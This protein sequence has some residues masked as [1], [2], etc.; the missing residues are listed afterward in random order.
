MFPK[1]G[2]ELGVTDSALLLQER[3]DIDVD[4]AID[5]TTIRV[6]CP[7]PG[8]NRETSLGDFM[9]SEHGASVTQQ[10]VE[11]AAQAH[12]K[13]A[14]LDE[15]LAQALGFAAVR[16]KETGGLARVE[17]V[18]SKKN[19][20]AEPDNQ[21]AEIAN[22][23]KVAST[24]PTLR[25]K[26]IDP[27]TRSAAIHTIKA[28][29]ESILVRRHSMEASR[30]AA[31][32]RTEL[33]HHPAIT[34][35][36]DL[37]HNDPRVIAKKESAG[38]NLL[39]VATKKSAPT[40]KFHKPSVHIPP[41]TH[42][43][44]VAILER[45][46]Q[47]IPDTRHQAIINDYVISPVIPIK[48]SPA[49]VRLAPTQHE[50]GLDDDALLLFVNGKNREIPIDAYDTLEQSLPEFELASSPDNTQLV[51]HESELISTHV[52]LE[53]TPEP[54]DYTGF[55][56]MEAAS[57]TNEI[58]EIYTFLLAATEIEA[59]AAPVLD[60]ELYE[61]PTSGLVVTEQSET[62][63]SE[64]TI[65]FQV[66]LLTSHMLEP[67]PDNEILL[68]T[69]HE[70][71][72]EETLVLLSMY[73]ADKAESQEPETAIIKYSLHQMVKL[74]PRNTVYG[75][76]EAVKKVVTPGF[77]KILVLLLRTVGY[78]NPEQILAEL[79]N[80]H[81]FEFLVQAIRYLYQLCDENDQLELLLPH[82]A[83]PVAVITE[84][85]FS[86]RLGRALLYFIGKHETF[87]LV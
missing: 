3:L 8:Q 82:L 26:V 17:P 25:E 31:A 10:I 46:S 48:L 51:L 42:G 53:P 59:A 37:R 61:A 22:S 27:Q 12:E 78:E 83:A 64:T 28:T 47:I 40:S 15:A 43:K 32:R 41:V 81:S 2:P 73:L 75:V 18:E 71:P 19:L 62:G 39:P 70:K 20:G 76:P 52:V 68:S 49:G 66:S 63:E 7:F 45:P 21:K 11:T 74:L 69:A 33:V 57:Y 24:F 30:L 50:A 60:A 80:K 77:T 36:I 55:E 56:N 5:L 6:V 87:S 16:D 72:L 86:V 58:M 67:S 44:K 54:W 14:T 84:K 29:E 35:H 34:G 1:T 4:Q 65:T 23:V 85:S 79:I 38:S 9:A 13:G